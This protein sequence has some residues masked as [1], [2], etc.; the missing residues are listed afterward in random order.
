MSNTK[1]YA[2]KA[3]QRY[4]QKHQWQVTNPLTPTR[5]LFF[6]LSSNFSCVQGMWIQ[7][8]SLCSDV[9]RR[10]GDLCRIAPAYLPLSTRG[11]NSI[12]FLG[13]IVIQGGIKGRQNRETQLS[14]S[15][16]N[17]LTSPTYLGGYSMFHNGLTLF[18]FRVQRILLPKKHPMEK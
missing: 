6:L 1:R 15:L 9:G 13:L 12:D 14:Q 17:Q 3:Q 2:H 7:G 11:S 5:L 4:N 16:S 10:R 8:N 18:F